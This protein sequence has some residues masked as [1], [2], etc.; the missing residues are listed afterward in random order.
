M[1]D[2]DAVASRSS[3]VTE[4]RTRRP[5]D[6][7]AVG[8]LPRPVEDAA[9]GFVGLAFMA[10]GLLVWLLFWF[11]V[12]E[13]PQ[14]VA[15]WGPAGFAALFFTAGIFLARMGFRAPRW[16]AER[17]FHGGREP[18]GQ[19]YRWSRNARPL[20]PQRRLGLLDRGIGLIMIAS[21]LGVVNLVWTDLKSVTGSAGAVYLVIPLLSLAMLAVVVFGL[22]GIVIEL[23]EGRGTLRFGADSYPARR[24]GS[25]RAEY[26]RGPRQAQMNDVIATLY[27]LE[28]DIG[29]GRRRPAASA[30]YSQ[31]REFSADQDV[32]GKNRTSVQFVL[33]GDVP[34]TD[35]ERGEGR[36]C[37]LLQVVDRDA[38]GTPV[39]EPETFLVPVY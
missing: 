34:P 27:C 30:V 7:P 13:P 18:W 14:G 25:F 20:P 9:P 15:K 38:G 10:A 1:I 12:D 36:R 5:A 3:P 2:S 21:L 39:A 37:W 28:I 11:G 32:E 26:E 33:P 8:W 31:T 19:R 6:C 16:W 35:L 17:R 4:D 24:G 29:A 23:R 22:Y